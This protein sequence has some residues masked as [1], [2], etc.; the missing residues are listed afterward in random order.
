[1]IGALAGFCFCLGFWGLVAWVAGIIQAPLLVVLLPLLLP[2]PAVLLLAC[3]AG[4]RE[5]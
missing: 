2:L 3:F 1:M 4:E 5:L